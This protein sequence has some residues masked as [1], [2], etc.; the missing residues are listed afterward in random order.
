VTTAALA[1][2]ISRLENRPADHEGY[3]TDLAE[4]K[5]IAAEL[6]EKVPASLILQEDDGDMV[7]V[8]ITLYF[9]VARSE[10]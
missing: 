7:S 5:R 9:A 3:V 8:R 1:T 4:V 10:L 2:M 6:T